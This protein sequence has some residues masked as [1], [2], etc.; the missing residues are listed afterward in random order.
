MP[1][2]LP[3]AEI[4]GYELPDNAGED[5]V[6]NLSIWDG[7]AA[8]PVRE[9]TVHHSINGSFSIRKGQWKL[10]MC[11]GSGGWSDPT[12]RAEIIA[13]LPPIQLYNLA[14]DIGETTN[15]Q[16]QH[17]EIVEEL[18]ALL[19]KYVKEGRSTPGAPQKNTGCPYWEQLTWLDESAMSP[20]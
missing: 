19:T 11:P 9:A 12:P 13:S 17:P 8:D 6:S 1:H 15:V 16:E 20:S 18:M 3:M 10:E 7:T 5:S 14:E 2:R 4:S